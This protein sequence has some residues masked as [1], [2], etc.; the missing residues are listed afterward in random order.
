ML[1]I[2]EY[3]SCELFEVVTSKTILKRVRFI[4]HVDRGVQ[5][6]WVCKRDAR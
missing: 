1:I 3:E 6:C 5:Q 2:L 4:M